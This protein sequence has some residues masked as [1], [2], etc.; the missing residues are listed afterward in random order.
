MNTFDASRFIRLFSNDA[1]SAVE[2]DLDRHA[3]ARGI[4]LISYVTNVDPH[5]AERPEIYGASVL[6]RADRGRVSP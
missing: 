5:A 6:R 1:A 3:R 2:E 4:G